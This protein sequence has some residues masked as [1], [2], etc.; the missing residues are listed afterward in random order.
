MDTPSRS[1]VFTPDAALSSTTSTRPSSSR[2]TSSTYK[3]P[4]LALACKPENVIFDQTTQSAN[5]DRLYVRWSVTSRGLYGC[6]RGGNLH[7]IA[8]WM[9]PPLWMSVLS[10]ID[11]RLSP[12]RCR[13]TCLETMIIMRQ[14]DNR[15]M[16]ARLLCSHI[17]KKVSVTQ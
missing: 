9:S 15:P 8:S 3:M 11:T 12:M 10:L 16:F 5:D 13:C 14:V 6:F 4:R 2:L 1:T 7:S 17:W